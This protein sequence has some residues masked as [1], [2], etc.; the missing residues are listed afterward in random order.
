[1][2]IALPLIIAALAV[3]PL[4]LF[5]LPTA[6]YIAGIA[7]LAVLGISLLVRDRQLELAEVEANRR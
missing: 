2:K 4:S 3:L 6:G 5:S 7:F 1:M